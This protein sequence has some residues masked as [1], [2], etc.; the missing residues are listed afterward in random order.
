[1]AKNERHPDDADIRL[2]FESVRP[3]VTPPAGSRERLERK[4]REAIR[5]RE[6]AS[7]G[8]HEHRLARRWVLQGGMA[9]AAM[10]MV[11]FA[12]WWLVGDGASP[13][14][15][16]FGEMIE[17][18]RQARSAAYTLILHIPG[19]PDERA[20]VLMAGQGNARITWSDGKTE[21]YSYG[22]C[23]WLCLSPATRRAW[24][25]DSPATVVFDEPLDALRRATEADGE[26]VGKETLDGHEV[27]VYRVR[28]VRGALRVW[29]DPRD[30]LPLR[31]EARPAG[32]DGLKT[33]VLEDFRWNMVIPESVFRLDVPPGYALVRPEDEA[34]EE[35]LVEALRGCAERSDGFFPASFGRDMV[36]NLVFEDNEHTQ[37]DSVSALSELGE[38]TK[39]F[40]RTC[41]SGLAFVEQ[42]NANGGWR[43]VGSGARLGDGGRPICW[44]RLPEREMFRVVYGDL[45]VCDV[46]AGQ[47]PQAELK[48]EQ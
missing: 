37:I 10:A 11:A 47:L 28:Q 45:M 22:N 44:W 27:A 43:Y 33:M 16:A 8:R 40:Y 13:A 3:D 18:V 25:H 4:L 9:A 19:R 23:K 30:N 14:S 39:R 15:A 12:C 24:L 32:D 1:M 29:C 20:E 36:A 5:A 46:P 48:G 38:E 26:L 42:V 31:V 34:S 6:L 2:L 17:Q 7:A 21:I 35:A 41:L